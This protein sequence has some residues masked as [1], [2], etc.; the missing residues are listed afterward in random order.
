M[1]DLWTTWDNSSRRVMRPVPVS[2]LGRFNQ[3]NKE[4]LPKFGQTDNASSSIET[5]VLINVQTWDNL[6][7]GLDMIILHIKSN[8]F[9]ACNQW[10]LS[11]SRYILPFLSTRFESIKDWILKS[12]HAKQNIFLLT[13]SRLWKAGSDGCHC[14]RNNQLL[15]C[16]KYFS[17]WNGTSFSEIDSQRLSCEFFFF[18]IFLAKN[19]VILAS[20]FYFRPQ[21]PKYHPIIFKM[22]REI[23]RE[24]KN[25][26]ELYATFLRCWSGFK[27][28]YYHSIKKW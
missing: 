10:R 17:D 16:Q 20:N 9:G 3:T 7:N 22:I 15:Y 12:P 21:A 13:T 18:G 23:F 25:L 2:I 4:C 8:N 24:F 5:P 27:W 19:W 26:T 11:L 6:G 28:V 14:R 1:Y